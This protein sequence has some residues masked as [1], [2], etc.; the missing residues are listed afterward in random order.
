MNS[1]PAL[2]TLY[3]LQGSGV[4]GRREAAERLEAEGLVD[5]ERIVESPTQFRQ[6][7]LVV[8]ILG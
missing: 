1:D 5:V 8:N 4:K 3:R 7:R 2:P 6:Q